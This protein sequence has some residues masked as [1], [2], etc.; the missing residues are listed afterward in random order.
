MIHSYPLEYFALYSNAWVTHGGLYTFRQWNNDVLSLVRRLPGDTTEDAINQ[1]KGD[2][3]EVFSE[4]FFNS[5]ENDEALGI[6]EYTPGS[7]DITVEDFGVDAIGINA[8]GHRCA[9][10]VKFRS[11]PTDQITY[12]DIARTFTSAI[13][14]HD[15]MDVVNFPHT[16]FLFTNTHGV[17]MA[18][19]KVLGNKAV[20]VTNGVIS[21][22]VDNNISFWTNA[23]QLM[24]NTLS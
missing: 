9:I 18:F 20:L 21:E 1:F 10:Q 2:M 6:K 13:I 12:A 11:N 14:Q 3:L 17:T 7:A 8:N 5:F 16:V 4:I 15:L 23:Y 24:Y 19:D 22:K